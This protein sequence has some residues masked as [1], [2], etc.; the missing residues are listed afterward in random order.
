MQNLVHTQESVAFDGLPKTCPIASPP[1]AVL[2]AHQ[3]FVFWV[4]NCRKLEVA[5]FESCVPTSS[6]LIAYPV[7]HHFT[8][9]AVYIICSC[10]QSYKDFCFKSAC[11]RAKNPCF[12]QSIGNKVA[13]WNPGPLW[14]RIQVAP[15][16][17]ICILSNSRKMQ[18][19]VDIIYV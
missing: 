4:G 15:N 19:S 9:S 11:E 5:P 18:I 10:L 6:Q 12:L 8:T 7:A 1:L 2:V 17:D 16:T 3:G 14:N 13:C